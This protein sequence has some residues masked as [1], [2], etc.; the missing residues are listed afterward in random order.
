MGPSSFTFLYIATCLPHKNHKTLLAAMEILR[1]RGIAA[2]LVLSATEKQLQQSYDAKKVLSLIKSGQILPLG[3]VNKEQLAAIYDASDACVMPSHLEQLSSA[4]LEAMHWKKSQISAD[5]AFAH[6][7]CGDASL[8]ANPND[9]NDWADKM[10]ALIEYPELRNQLIANG[11]NRMK[12][13]PQS[14]QEVARKEK[15]FLEAIRTRLV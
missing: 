14:W 6:D 9:P 8:Y 5:L 11:V 3:W 10:Q 7:L 1:N 12:Y 4:N 2:R 13:F 15:A